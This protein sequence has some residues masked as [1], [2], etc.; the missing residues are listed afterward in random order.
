MAGVGENRHVDVSHAL[1]GRR[2]EA[3]NHFATLLMYPAI[4]LQ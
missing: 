1:L 2:S 4:S 3:A